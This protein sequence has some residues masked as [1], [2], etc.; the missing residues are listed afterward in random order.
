VEAKRLICPSCGR[1]AY[2]KDVNRGNA[3]LELVLWLFFLLPGL[4]YSIWRRSAK[5]SKCPDCGTTD[6]V[7]IDSFRGKQIIEEL[8]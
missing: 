5:H 8:A 4:V 1:K 7:P 3:A 6:M 2:V